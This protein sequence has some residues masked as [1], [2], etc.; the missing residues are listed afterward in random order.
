MVHIDHF[1]A[2][3]EWSHN[4]SDLDQL[5]YY[6]WGAGAMLEAYRKLEKKPST[7]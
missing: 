3:D 2:K 7:I 1:I 5:D 6:V 4:S